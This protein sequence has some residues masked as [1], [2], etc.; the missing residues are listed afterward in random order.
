MCAVCMSR[1]ETVRVLVCVCAGRYLHVTH[2]ELDHI[3]ND[4]R[5][6]QSRLLKI[7]ATQ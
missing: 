5:P 6:H 3:V 1:V 7:D 2:F 4:T